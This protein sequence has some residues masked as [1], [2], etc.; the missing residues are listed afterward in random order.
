MNRRLA[1]SLLATLVAS[2]CA[3]APLPAPAV[4]PLRFPEPL[5]RSLPNGLRVVVFPSSSL[6]I[7]QAQLLVPA[8][9]ANEPDSLPG[10]AALTAQLIQGGSA[11]RTAEQMAA[12]LGA[13]GATL[14][15]GA[16][17]DYALVAC[18][19][20]TAAFS[21]LL[22]IMAD[23]VLNPRLGGDE[24]ESV[25]R[26][27]AA[28]LRTKSMNAATLTDDRIWGIAFDPHPYGHADA[29][30]IEALMGTRLEHA[31]TFLRER[32]R[33]DHAVLAIAG[34]IDPERAFAAA[35]SAFGRWAGRTGADR[36]R[37]A[38]AR[39]AGVHLAELSGS[40]RAEVRVALVGPGR[41]SADLAA[42]RLAQASLEERLAGTG[43]TVTLTTLRDASLLVLARSV[44]VDS[45]RA[46]TSRLTGALHAFASAP[47]AGDATAA[48]WRR[49]RQ[50]LPLSLETLGSRMSRWQA[51]D[52]AGAH[53]AD[54]ATPPD[55][56]PAVRAFAGSPTVLVAGPLDRL[57]TL[58]APLGAVSEVPLVVRHRTRPDTLAAPTASE[59]RAGRA[60]VAAAVTAAGGAAR[61]AS[62]QAIATEGDLTINVGGQELA[63][64]FS[65]VRLDP[66]RLSYSTR[67]LNF[68]LRQ[69]LDGDHAWALTSGDTASLSEP[70]S[71]GIE[72]LRTLL[73]SDLVHLLRQ[74]S[75]AGS[76]AALR[77]HERINERECQLVDFVGLS[78]RR[79]R[80]AIDPAD[81]QVV[82]LDAAL[83]DDLQWHDRRIFSV[84]KPVGG[85]VLPAN[86]ERFVDGEL[87]T[88][89]IS[90]AL[91]VD[92]QVDP[93]LFRRPLVVGGRII[94]GR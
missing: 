56:A 54:A 91:R 77:G 40:P 53:A 42:W 2:T 67:M 76:H 50:A 34:D 1:L 16:T 63:G 87:V 43:T 41:A 26:S 18:G 52:F 3:A 79:L 48:V 82:A 71:I 13:L 66:D 32:W 19:G 29:G 37:P 64:Q 81:H 84:W 5:S 86:E 25:R 60:M 58:L 38:P 70:D 92:P 45:A 30:D 28:Q 57:R 94:P 73:N 9:V 83:G 88:R 4:P 62:V 80:L 75:D 61:L 51:D 68:E 11:S 22:E 44:P 24:F 89:F 31:M 33:P 21:E 20:R 74:A 85:L 17:R 39:S 55:L 15:T 47:P 10:L 23:A 6:P 27:V 35:D 69:V 78:G 8:G 65:I 49:V 12:D 36:G 93:H 59:L 72:S 7:V 46:A 14:T 90:R